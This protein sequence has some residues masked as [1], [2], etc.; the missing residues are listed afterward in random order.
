MPA[1][2]AVVCA[3]LGIDVAKAKLD[4]VLHF[5]DRSIHQVFANTPQ[6]FE[7]LD[8]WVQ[9]ALGLRPEQ[10]HACLEATGSYSDAIASFLFVHGYTVSVLPT[11]VLVDYRKVKQLRSK[12]DQL[13]AHLLARYG[14]EEQPRSWK[15]L[16]PAIL[17]LRALLAYRDDVQHMLRQERNR[18]EAGRMTDW[19]R[20]QVAG[21][22]TQLQQQLHQAERQIKAHLKQHDE[23]KAIWG[24]LQSIPG[25]GW[26]SAARLLAHLGEISRFP[27]VGSVVSLA[28]L[29]VKEVSSGTS[30]RGHAQIDRHGRKDLRRAMYMCA[31]V[32]RR[33]SPH[34]Q[35][36]AKRLQAQGKP[37][38][39]ILVAIMR[40]LL[41]IAYGVW[42]TQSDYD[43]TV[44]FPTA[45]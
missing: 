7:A 45:A 24:R 44:A 21:H 17:T 13:D 2:V 29:A 10:V 6:G 16:P 22:V 25:I 40:K 11:A 35:A 8:S 19:I 41:H 34:M 38:K 18:Q 32:A 5:A 26:L 14:Q 12:T 33:C 28:G 1:L 3:Y 9:Q 30:V 31:V 42:K 23:L 36:W 39:V 27:K 15:P 43:P 37:K 20:Q 4:V